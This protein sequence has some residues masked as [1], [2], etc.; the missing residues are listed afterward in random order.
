MCDRLNQKGLYWR[1]LADDHKLREYGQPLQCLAHAILLTLGDNPPT[2]YKFP[3]SK[4]SIHSARILLKALDDE[5]NDPLQAFHSFV[6]PFFSGQ[7]FVAHE[8]NSVYNKW[9]DVMECFLAV[10][11][12]N[13][14]GTFKQAQDVTQIFAKLEYICRGVTLTQGLDEKVHF[15]NDPYRWVNAFLIIFG[16]HTQEV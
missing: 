13:E 12:L 8:D 2:N 5:E 1:V 4:A 14:D 6:A 10:Y 9:N 15:Q 3:L 7:D 11:C 16:T